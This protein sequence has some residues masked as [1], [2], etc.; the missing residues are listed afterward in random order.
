MTT[1]LLWLRQDLRLADQPALQ[2]A[3]ERG[4]SIIPVF[5]WSPE[6]EGEWQPGAASRWWLHQSLGKLSAAI[7]KRGSKLILRRA[8]DSLACLRELL[9]E[10]GAT[11]VYWGRRYEPLIIARDAHIKNELR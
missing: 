3:I 5:I 2:A 11:A 4:G 1:T 7:E 8:T 9:A 10:T 6:E